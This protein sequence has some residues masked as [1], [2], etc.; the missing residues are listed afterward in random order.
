M[1]LPLT[2]AAASCLVLNEWLHK[3]GAEAGSEGALCVFLEACR[4][5]H[6]GAAGLSAASV[7]WPEGCVFVCFALW[8]VCEERPG[9]R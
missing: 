6:G 5:E 3:C 8:C 9:E 7:T 2:T 1:Y 4:S